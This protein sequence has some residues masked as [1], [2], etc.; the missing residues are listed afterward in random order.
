MKALVCYDSNFGNT[1]IIAETIALEFG[2]ETKTF[3]ISNPSDISLY[4]IELLIVGSPIVGWKP[5]EK[6]Q[7]F[8]ASLKTGQLN[9]IKAAAF[10]TRIKLFI[11]GDA[12][13]KINEK[14][15]EL[16]AEIIAEPQMFYVKG[17][18]GPLFKEEIEKAK[19]WALLLINKLHQY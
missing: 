4:E 10:D 12:A 14:L 17:K 19:K 15:I 18:E 11:H 1:K 7:A 16:G 9:K 8:L 6:M 3:C 5:T 13:K 2:E